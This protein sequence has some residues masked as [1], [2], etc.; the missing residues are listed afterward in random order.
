VSRLELRSR[1]RPLPLLIALSAVA[2]VVMACGD[3]EPNGVDGE[4]LPAQTGPF[5]Q[6]DGDYPS[7]CDGRAQKLRDC[8]LLTEGPVRCFDLPPAL[9]ACYFACF[10]EASCS[11]LARSHCVGDAP[12]IGRCLEKCEIYDCGDGTTILQ[13]WVCDHAADCLDGRDELD[14]EYFTCDN[15]MQVAIDDVCDSFPDCVDYSD[16]QD[17]PTFTCENGAVIRESWRC[18]FEADCLDGSDEVDCP[19]FTCASTGEKLPLS[20]Q[21]DLEDDCLDGSDEAGCAQLLCR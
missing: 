20:W 14:C 15:A 12:P 3:G 21:C 2:L 4:E 7:S 8:G 17:C 1:K 13:S 11:L 10:T 19:H 5:P 18:D 16:E 6:V 9:E